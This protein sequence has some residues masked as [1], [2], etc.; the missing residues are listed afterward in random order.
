MS[1][2]RGLPGAVVPIAALLFT[3]TAARAAAPT[4]TLTPRASRTRTTG[5]GPLPVWD[6]K[7]WIDIQS[8]HAAAPLTRVEFQARFGDASGG[9]PLGGGWDVAA[10]DRDGFAGR[11]LVT[12]VVPT[13][14][15]R[16]LR[17]QLRVR[18]AAGG[19]S[20]WKEAQFP[21]RPDAEALPAT[22]SSGGEP[23]D[24]RLGGVLAEVDDSMTIADAKAALQRKARALSGDAVGFRVVSS[25]EGRS[26]FAADV[27]RHATA[28]PAAATPTALPLAERV[29][30]EIIMPGARR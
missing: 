28:L 21:V 2:L 8:P 11:V 14:Y 15:D 20:D 7:W 1:R 9:R 18:D 16:P 17:V 24:E 12:C 10:A 23:G 4:L 27:I 13:D 22:A 30:G 25:S 26:T 29:L 5:V 3:T 6:N 19:I